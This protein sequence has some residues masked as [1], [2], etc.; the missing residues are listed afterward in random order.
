MK[1]RGRKRIINERIRKGMC[2]ECRRGG[3]GDSNN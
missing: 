3:R 2:E 1:N